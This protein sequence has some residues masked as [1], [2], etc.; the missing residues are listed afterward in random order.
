MNPIQREQH[1]KLLETIMPSVCRIRFHSGTANGFLCVYQGGVTGEDN[2][3][4]LITNNRVISDISIC[5]LKTNIFEFPSLTN[6]K[7]F[8]VRQ[9]IIEDA[10]TNWECDSTVIEITQGM[11]DR[12]M[13]QGARFLEMGPPVV[14]K[15][16]AAIGY[17]KGNQISFD[18][19]EIWTIN[20]DY[21]I[22]HRSSTKHVRCGGPLVN[23][24]GKVVG[25]HKG[26]NS[27]KMNE[28]VRLKF[29][30]NLYFQLRKV[31]LNSSNKGQVY[32]PNN[33]LSLASNDRPNM[34]FG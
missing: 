2:S 17:P 25:I 14:G 9:E 33:E 11:A 21:Q 26:T 6:L 29:V 1:K 15:L 10:W 19:G 8:Q 30:L 4:L 34:A 13:D 31:A 16:A 20:K 5:S 7:Q 27:N 28:A 18:Y 23:M 24:E 12:M 22:V 32:N 3:F